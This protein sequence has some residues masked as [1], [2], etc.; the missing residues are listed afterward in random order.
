M[1]RS[2]SSKPTPDG[3]PRQHFGGSHVSPRDQVV[4]RS[5]IRGGGDRANPFRPPVVTTE[6][7]LGLTQQVR[8]LTGII[9]AI[10]PC[11]PQLAQ[12]PI[13]QHPHIPRQT[14]QQEAPQS[15]P[16]QGEH[17]D[18]APH[19]PIEATIEN[20]IASVSQPTNRSRDVIRL[21][22]EPDVVS[23]N[24]TNSVREQLRQVN[25]RLD[26]VQRDFVRSK[27]EV[28]ETTKGGSPFAPEI[29][30]KPIPSS[31]RLPTLEPYNGSTDPTEH[32]VAFRAQMALYDTSD[33]LMCRTFPTTLRGP[34]RMWY[35][36]IK[37]SSISSFDQFARPIRQQILGRDPK[38]ARHSS[39]SSNPSI[40]DGTLAL[41]I[42]LV[43]D[44]EA[45]IHS[46]RD[47]TTDEPICS[48]RVIGGREAG[49]SQEA[50]R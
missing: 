9:Q 14:L 18:G 20:P 13:H 46:A 6:A 43:V 47:V 38:D 27:E 3:Q 17:P 39:Y 40:P 36:R 10:V 5:G 24:S 45:P 23:S 2:D 16:S 30:D 50:P 21:P 35:N 34:A 49:R 48:R 15:R 28:E 8:T 33:A 26:E 25:Q 4:S 12:V 19:P 1:G 32:V 29:M 41:T 44:R 42:L 7:F 37:L 22:P 31:F 11:I